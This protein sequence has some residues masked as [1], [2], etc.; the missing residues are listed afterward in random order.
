M[1]LYETQGCMGPQN[2]RFLR[3][4]RI[5]R[6]QKSCSHQPGWH[7]P[8]DPF[9]CPK[10]PGWNPEAIP[11]PGDVIFSSHDVVNP[12]TTN[13]PPFYNIHVY[14]KNQPNVGTWILIQNIIQLKRKITWTIH[15]HVT[16]ASKNVFIFRVVYIYT[17]PKNPPRFPRLPFPFRNSLGCPRKLGSM[18]R[19][20]GLF[21]L[22][23]NG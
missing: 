14:N 4:F 8:M 9:L 3:G 15:L 22:L 12:Q 6:E 16:W 5:L 23:I 11:W 1:N 10:D 2:S 19:I 17:S 13:I 20:N 21:H 7:Y 18:V